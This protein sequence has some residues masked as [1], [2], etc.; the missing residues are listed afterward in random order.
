V[1]LT[2]E[3]YLRLHED[4]V[5]RELQIAFDEV[6]RGEVADL[7]MDAIRAEAHRRYAAGQQ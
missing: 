7:D 5:R 3:D 2:K 6:D 4:Y 1:L